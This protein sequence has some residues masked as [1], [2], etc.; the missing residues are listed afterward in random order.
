ML[1]L[2]DRSLDQSAGLQAPVKKQKTKEIRNQRLQLVVKP[3]LGAL[4]KSDAKSA[5][6]SVNEFLNQII[7][8]HYEVQG[9]YEDD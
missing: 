6:M 3:S 4:I 2:L 5:D 8:Y 7:I 1:A 9:R